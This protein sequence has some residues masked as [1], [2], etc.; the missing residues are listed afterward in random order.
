[1]VFHLIL[2]DDDH[3]R[4]ADGDQVPPDLERRE[5]LDPER[6]NELNRDHRRHLRQDT[7]VNP[8]MLAGIHFG[9]E[10]PRERPQPL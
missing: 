1:M 5:I 6:S 7:A 3:K 10:R 8:P 9:A 4:R 2:R